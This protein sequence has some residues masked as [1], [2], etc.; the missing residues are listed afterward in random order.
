MLVEKLEE[1]KKVG[2]IKDFKAVN[3][4]NGKIDYDIKFFKDLPPKKA[5]NKLDYYLAEK[6][7]VE[8]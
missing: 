2:I 1:I 3:K 8:L 4:P 7:G 5:L 6:I